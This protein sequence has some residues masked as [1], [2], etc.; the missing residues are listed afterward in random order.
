M[1]RAVILCRPGMLKPL[2]L[3]LLQREW[4]DNSGKVE[5]F[6]SGRSAQSVMSWQKQ[7][8]ER[9]FIEEVLSVSISNALSQV[10]SV[11]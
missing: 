8:D 7:S 9:Q 6:L 4:V 5:A 2:L 3:D 11:S 1:Y 10:C